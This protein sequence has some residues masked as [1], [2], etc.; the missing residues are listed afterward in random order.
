MKNASKALVWLICREIGL[1]EEEYRVVLEGMWGYPEGGD[2]L[3]RTRAEIRR[4][5]PDTAS[6]LHV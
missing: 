6:R 4:Q 5:M 2:V 3:E 1:T